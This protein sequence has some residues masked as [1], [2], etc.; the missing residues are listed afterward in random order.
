MKRVKLIEQYRHTPGM[1]STQDIRGFIGEDLV[2]AKQ[3]ALANPLYKHGGT[4]IYNTITMCPS[5]LSIS[6]DTHPGER[7]HEC[8]GVKTE[9]WEVEKDDGK[10]IHEF[11]AEVYVDTGH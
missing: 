4:S 3:Y 5:D 9:L 2:R 11:V 1:H 10:F 6:N 8:Y 7:F